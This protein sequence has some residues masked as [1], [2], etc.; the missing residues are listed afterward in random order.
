MGLNK[1]PWIQCVIMYLPLLLSKRKDE[2]SFKWLAALCTTMSQS[3][4]GVTQA[5]NYTARKYMGAEHPGLSNN[6]GFFIKS[7]KDG[8]NVLYTMQQMQDASG[9]TSLVQSWLKTVWWFAGS[10]RSQKGNSTYLSASNQSSNWPWKI[11]IS[12]DISTILWAWER[13][14]FGASALLSDSPVSVLLNLGAS[15][16]WRVHM[17]LAAPGA[18]ALSPGWAGANSRAGSCLFLLPMVTVATSVWQWHR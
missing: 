14:E 11:L 5:N 17:P 12:T 2:Y 3:N 7:I 18:V 9:K 15:S 13:S 6:C 16:L 8:F 4:R 10:Y 1:P